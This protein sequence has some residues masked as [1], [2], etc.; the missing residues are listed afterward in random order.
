[1]AFIFKMWKS[2]YI[3]YLKVVVWPLYTLLRTVMISISE[4]PAKQHGWLKIKAQ[5]ASAI[6]F[7]CCNYQST[8]VT[9][10]DYDHIIHI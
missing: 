5:L 6:M 8:V 2:C 7:P 3:W 9:E 1:M 10:N 4:F